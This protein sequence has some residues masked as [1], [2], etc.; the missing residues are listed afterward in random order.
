MMASTGCRNVWR[1]SFMPASNYEQRFSK[2]KMFTKK[3]WYLLD[4]LHLQVFLVVE[5][6]CVY[7]SNTFQAVWDWGAS[8]LQCCTQ[9]HGTTYTRM[10]IKPGKPGSTPSCLAVVGATVGAGEEVVM[11]AATQAPLYAKTIKNCSSKRKMKIYIT[12][13]C[14]TINTGLRLIA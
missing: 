8:M 14:D 13:G 4:L 1:S 10:R 5:C 9:L 11:G 7:I 6:F 2:S 3:F 12:D